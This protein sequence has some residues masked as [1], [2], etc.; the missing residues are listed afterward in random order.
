MAVVAPRLTLEVFDLNRPIAF[1]RTTYLDTDDLA[2]FGSCDQPISRRL[3]VREYAGASN[4]DEEPTLSGITFLELKESAGP[5]RSKARFAAPAD[6]I[7]EII[8][9]GGERPLAWAGMLRELQTFQSILGYLKEG[10]LKPRVTTWYRRAAL[11]GAKGS[12]RVTLDESIAFCR[13]TLC[14]DP[15][16]PNEILAVGPGRVLEVKYHGKPPEWLTGELGR[17]EEAPAFSKFRVGMEHV[18]KL[19]GKRPGKL[20]RPIEIPARLRV[21]KGR[22]VS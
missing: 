8:E 20:T 14:V 17:L 4:L 2:F 6:A 18:R 9:S 7:A 13:P 11:S 5:V 10:R 16:Q 19:E 22:G 3:R 1:T 21:R 12:L 15:A